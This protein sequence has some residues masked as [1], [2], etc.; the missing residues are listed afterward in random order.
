MTRAQQFAQFDEQ[1]PDIYAEYVA[2]AKQLR[3]Q[4]VQ[5]YSSI[6]LLAVIR[7]QRLTSNHGVKDS[8]F[9]INNNYAP[10]Y[11]R[12]LADEYPIEFG[13]FFEMRTQRAA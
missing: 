8:G 9:A 4:G 12:K 5:R 13:E 2:C 1:H 10:Y 7:Y 6:G 11:A 3:L